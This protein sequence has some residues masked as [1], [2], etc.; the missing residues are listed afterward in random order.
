MFREVQISPSDDIA[1]PFMPQT[2][3]HLDILGLDPTQSVNA[4][5]LTNRLAA[6]LSA[7]HTEQPLTAHLLTLV[8]H[9]QLSPASSTAHGLNTLVGPNPFRT[10]PR[11]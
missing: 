2:E 7:E 10:F 1:P 11:L 5:V 9:I 4:F 8:S 3:K 6:R